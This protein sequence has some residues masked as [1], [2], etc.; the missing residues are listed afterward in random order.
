MQT[1]QY[2]ALHVH[3]KAR[4]HIRHIGTCTF[5][6]LYSPHRLKSS[7]VQF[8]KSYEEL[9][10]LRHFVKSYNTVTVLKK[11][12]AHTLSYTDIQY[13]HAHIH[14]HSVLHRSWTAA[15]LILTS[16]WGCCGLPVPPQSFVGG[17]GVQPVYR[18]LFEGW[19]GLGYCTL[20][21]H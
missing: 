9:C 6:T 11:F 15:T 4:A 18:V 17:G 1:N 16:G 2:L 12:H 3:M 21:L 20:S 5:C 8:Q 19:G 10:F 7:S 14:T 13:T